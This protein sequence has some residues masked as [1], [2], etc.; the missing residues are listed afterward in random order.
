[1]PAP[2]L[3][4]WRATLAQNRGLFPDESAAVQLLA[5]STLGKRRRVKGGDNHSSGSASAVC[6]NGTAAGQPAE[7]ALVLD[8]ATGDTSSEH[9]LESPSVWGASAVAWV[10]AAFGGTDAISSVKRE[11]ALYLLERGEGSTLSMAG[12]KLPAV[13][14]YRKLMRASDPAGPAAVLKADSE[15][16]TYTSGVAGLRWDVLRSKV[17]GTGGGGP[18]P[19]RSCVSGQG[20][21]ASPPLLPSE[22]EPLA[23]ATAIRQQP[24]HPPPTPLPTTSVSKAALPNP[25]TALQPTIPTVPEAATEGHGVATKAL[26]DELLLRSWIFKLFTG[27]DAVSSV[28]REAAL[29]LLSLGDGGALAMK[30]CVG[31]LPAAAHYQARR[32]VGDPSS[33]RKVIK[34]DK[35][36]FKYDRPQK[37]VSLRLDV[38]RHEVHEASRAACRLPVS[39]VPRAAGSHA[40]AYGPF[41]NASAPQP[42][43][44]AASRPQAPPWL[45]ASASQQKLLES[46]VDPPKAKMPLRLAQP[47]HTSAMPPSSNALRPLAQLINAA[48]ASS[49]VDAADRGSTIHQEPC[50]GEDE[51][52]Q[53]DASLSMLLSI[54]PG[55]YFG[56][57]SHFFGCW[58]QPNPCQDR[59][60]R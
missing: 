16:F 28:K 44:P 24:D 38:L 2:L 6:N 9:V 29:R 21:M 1:M 48:N 53:L 42:A 32:L 56:S 43:Q 25:V 50:A 47:G 41:K 3:D 46:K 18:A 23:V 13:H 55:R 7:A 33:A 52:A 60:I 39:S 54:V 5:V 26:H 8:R 19:L 14:N 35:D 27:A 10:M 36:H 45:P 34:R 59:L 51:E 11:V 15:H 4:W 57:G 30:E 17:G 22:M 37:T 49:E 31:G 40:V 58:G 12:S 20:S